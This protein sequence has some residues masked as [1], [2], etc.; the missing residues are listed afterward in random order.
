M[1]NILHTIAAATAFAVLG[2]IMAVIALRWPL[3]ILAVALILM[4]AA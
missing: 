4:K 2:L 1:R 3:T